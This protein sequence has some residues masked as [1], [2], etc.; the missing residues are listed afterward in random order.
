MNTA[1]TRKGIQEFETHYKYDATFMHELLEYSQEGFKRFTNFQPM[2]RHRER[3]QPEVYWTVKLA[4]MQ[5]EDCGDCLQLNVRMA[6]EAGVP[7]AIVENIIY[8]TDALEPE[9]RDIHAFASSV[10]RSIEPNDELKTRIEARFDKGDLLEMG[11]AIAATRV[12]PAIKRTLGYTRQ[13]ALVELE[14]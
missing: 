5:A 12:F 3:L 6:L 14:I 10:A 9:L 4:S 1:E 11:L 7:R 2:A 8:N 13:C